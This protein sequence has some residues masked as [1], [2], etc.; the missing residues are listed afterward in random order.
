[1][2]EMDGLE[3]CRNIKAAPELADM[4]VVITTGYPGHPKLDEVAALGYTHV[5]SKPF[6]LRSLT[7]FVHRQLYGK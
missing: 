5:F 1:M 2:P 7:G 4:E 6:D 3:V